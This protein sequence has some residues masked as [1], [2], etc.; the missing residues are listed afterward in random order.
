MKSCRQKLDLR[1]LPVCPIRTAR[2]QRPEVAAAPLNGQGELLREGASPA[3]WRCR[4]CLPT[5]HAHRAG[6]GRIPLSGRRRRRRRSAAAATGLG[7]CCGAGPAAAA[8]AV[9][10][11]DRAVAAASRSCCRCSRTR[12]R[13]PPLPGATRW[14]VGCGRLGKGL[15]R[16]VSAGRDERHPPRPQRASG[17]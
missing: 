3:R 4:G 5:D 9:T 11:L 6:R 1:F 17:R 14:G 7:P 13:A 8:A 10:G 12:P 15:R 2:P 16:K